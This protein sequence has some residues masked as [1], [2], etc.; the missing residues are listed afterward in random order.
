[1]DPEEGEVFFGIKVAVR[2]F[3]VA[4]LVSSHRNTNTGG[5]GDLRPSDSINTAGNIGKE[6]VQSNM[7]V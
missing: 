1:M 4:C 5:S 3:L 2:I 6:L 7:L